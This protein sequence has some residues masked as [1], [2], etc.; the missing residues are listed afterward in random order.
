[1]LSFSSLMGMANPD[2]K[3][4]KEIENGNYNDLNSLPTPNLNKIYKN[5]LWNKKNF[6]IDRTL[7]AHA[8][9]SNNEE[10]GLT[11][12]K[13]GADPFITNVIWKNNKEM[14]AN[15]LQFAAAGCF[16]EKLIIKETSA[17]RAIL[18]KILAY[19]DLTNHI[20][21]PDNFGGNTAL[22]FAAW[23]GNTESVNLLLSK[24]ASID[25][26][27]KFGDTALHLAAENNHPEVVKILLKNKADKNIKNTDDGNGNKIS[28]TALDIAKEKKYTDIVALLEEVNPLAVLNNL[29]QTLKAKLVQLLKVTSG[30]AH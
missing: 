5:D 1:M 16:D 11:M 3:L 14:N 4:I 26:P 25:T 23:F 29:L 10:L 19:K 28:K 7:L 9:A 6:D 30:L 2:E 24:G 22:H 15:A 27:N 20:D 8:I 13:L 21:D 18:I 17:T 12:L